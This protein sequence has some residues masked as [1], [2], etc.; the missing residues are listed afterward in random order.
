LHA[1]DGRRLPLAPRDALLL[2]WLALEGPTDR[3]RVAQLLWPH[4]DSA[5]ARNALRQRLFQL[6]RQ[7]GLDLVAGSTV[8]RL[9]DSV[10]HDLPS[11]ESLLLGLDAGVGGEIDTWLAAQ[12]SRRRDAQRAGLCARMDAAEQTADWPLALGLSHELLALDPLSEDAHRRLMRLHYLAGDRAAALQAFD[13]CEQLLRDELSTRP[14]AVTLALLQTLEQAQTAAPAPA[15]LPLRQPPLAVL[16]PPQRVGRDAHWQALHA[17]WDA[18]L[19][20]LLLGEAGLGKTRL[21]SDF[22]GAQGATL[23]GARPGDEHVAYAALARLLRGLPDLVGLPDQIEPGVRVE[24]ARLLPELG[25]PPP[26]LVDDMARSRFLQALVQ[27]LAKRRVVFDDLHFADPASV[28]ALR[29]ATA[30]GG[31]RWLITSRPAEGGAAAQA[32]CAAW[33]LDDGALQLTLAPLTA[34]DVQTLLGTLSLDGLDPG[35]DGPALHRRCG[36]NPLF[37]LECLKS[38]WRGGEGAEAISAPVRALIERRISRL[39]PAAVALARCA[40]LAAPDFTADLAAQVLGVRTLELA[41]PWAELEAAQV[42]VDGVFVHDLVMEAARASVPRPV[43]QR[44]H[45]DIAQALAHSG[46]EP[47]R[48]AEHWWQAD[49]PAA[50]AAAWAQAA[51][52]LAAAGRLMDAAAVWEQ[53]ATAHARAGEPD[54]RFDALAA[55]LQLLAEEQPDAQAAEAAE[56]LMLLAETDAQQLR[57]QELRLSINS[58]GGDGRLVIESGPAALAQARRLA[59]H[60]RTL[61]LAVVVA[62]VLADQLRAREAVDLLRA[63][64]DLLPAASPE[65]RWT[66]LAALG[67]CLDYANRLRE[68][69]PVWAAAQDLAAAQ[70]RVDQLWKSQANLA[71][72]LN[73][74]GQVAAAVDLYTLAMQRA[75]ETGPRTLRIW[76]TRMSYGHRLRDSGR[77][78][79]AWEVLDDC[80]QQFTT[81]GSATDQAEV[82]HRL[83]QLYQQL[84]RPEQAAR[85]LADERADLQPR[86]R[87]I[88]LMHRA[89]LAHELGRDGVPLIHEALSLAPDRNEATYR[90]VSLFAT[91][92]LP[93]EEAEMLATSLVAWALARERMGLALAAHVRAAA[94][95]LAL[96]AP[97]RA[98]PHAEEALGLAREYRPDSF[99]LG[100]LWL[101]AGRVRAALGQHDDAAALWREGARWLLTQVQVPAAFTVSYRERNAVNRELLRLAG[102]PPTTMLA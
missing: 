100:E 29:L 52:R 54:A 16:R 84:G 43:A 85:L 1:P 34:A 15:A 26:P 17:A 13:A 2:A 5:S 102:P 99:W 73:K 83:A 92:L 27:V 55:R 81:A 75:D 41:D 90:M 21:A 45:A 77:L 32:W 50:A 18:G 9:A 60:E 40:A 10:A 65:T 79:D 74:L 51:Q 59:D 67:Y 42:L 14:S 20:V 95:A 7:T 66:F 23:A 57:A 19:P 68:A 49:K 11:A 97:E 93:P 53:A 86:L 96:A 24:L 48:L 6:R 12:R 78:G 80:L 38:G 98:W 33:P 88:R 3:G 8:L 63:H 44:L 64:E 61:N 69:L 82:E 56:N 39:S 37:L 72:T 101:V 87:M 25:P 22:A 58:T 30:A 4:A 36:G 35:Q 62:E 70:G 28:E 71:A 89:D 76:R 47:A 91:R 31:G 94:A 46:V